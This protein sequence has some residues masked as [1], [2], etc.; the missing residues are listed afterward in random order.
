MSQCVWELLCVER[1]FMINNNKWKKKNKNTTSDIST[2]NSLPHINCKEEKVDYDYTEK[3]LFKLKK[4]NKKNE[5]KF[6]NIIN[7]FFISDMSK[8][9]KAY[10]KKNDSNVRSEIGITSK[11]IPKSDEERFWVNSYIYNFINYCLLTYYDCKHYIIITYNQN[12]IQKLNGTGYGHYGVYFTDG[13]KI[14]GLG[15]LFINIKQ[16]RH[17]GFSVMKSL[18]TRIASDISA[19]NNDESCSFIV[20]V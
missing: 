9:V 18:H 8:Y 13:K 16:V 15:N 20:M 4:K 2:Y 12:L 3:N 10:V 19:S 1:S 11:K 6:K 17:I 14:E 5:L 7:Q